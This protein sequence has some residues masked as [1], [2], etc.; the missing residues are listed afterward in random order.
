MTERVVEPS[1]LGFVHAILSTHNHTDHLDGATIG[2]IIAANTD[3]RI[4]VPEAN[5]EFAAQRLDVA[6]DRL[7]GVVDSDVQWV[8]VARGIHARGIPASHELI[9]RDAAGRCMFLGY[10]ISIGL[11]HIYHSGDTVR[12]EGMV[13]AITGR[14]GRG[15]SRSPD[16]ALLP[17]NGRAPERRV[18]GNLNG[19]EAAQLAKDIGAKVVIPCHYDMF[20]FNTADPADEFVPECERI[21]QAHRVLQQGERFSGTEIP[22]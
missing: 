3:V 17:I 15:Y 13:D 16:I 7:V 4:L 2:P 12:Y 19:R 18:A 8:Q 5:R 14:R 21:A 6:A 1:R 11:Q 22:A 10:E 20:E 9:E